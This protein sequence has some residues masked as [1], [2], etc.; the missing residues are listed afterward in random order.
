MDIK[1]ITLKD[2]KELQIILRSSYRSV[3]RNGS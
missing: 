3:L 1:P 2:F